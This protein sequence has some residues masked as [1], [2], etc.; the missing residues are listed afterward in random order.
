MPRETIVIVVTTIIPTP[1][2]QRHLERSVAESRDLTPSDSNS[3]DPSTSL[4][5]TGGQEGRRAG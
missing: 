5:M 4:G 1:L 3:E 2:S